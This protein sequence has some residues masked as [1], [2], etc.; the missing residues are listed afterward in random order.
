MAET[1]PLKTF[2]FRTVSER[3]GL[4]DPGSSFDMV[5]VWR[6]DSSENFFGPFCLMRACMHNKLDMVRLLME[7]AHADVDVKDKEG[8]T[9]LQY[10]NVNINTA[11]GKEI[12]TRIRKRITKIVHD[13][14]PNIAENVVPGRARTG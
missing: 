2:P 13:Q 5:S 4:R 8:Y 12:V 6:I 1:F 14:M 9:A 11:E 7:R 3:S 10:A